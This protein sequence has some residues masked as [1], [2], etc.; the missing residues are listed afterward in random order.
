MMYDPKGVLIG[1]GLGFS[2]FLL[3]L[4]P[5]IIV[6]IMKNKRFNKGSIT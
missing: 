6:K 3:P 4:T 5:I 1:L 2:L